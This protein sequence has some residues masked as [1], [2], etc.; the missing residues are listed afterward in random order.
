MAGRW[1]TV[2]VE[3]VEGACGCSGLPVRKEPAISVPPHESM[4]GLYPARAMSHSTSS[5]ADASPAELKQRMAPQSRPAMQPL[6][7]Q[8]CGRQA[9]STRV[10]L[11][12]PVNCCLL[13]PSVLLHLAPPAPPHSHLDKAWHHTQH[14]DAGCLHKLAKGA[15]PGAAVQQ[16]DCGA[17]EQRCGWEDAEGEG[18]A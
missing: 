6:A 18:R 9:R 1:P 2:G 17:V 13:V 11:G 16:R 3:N 10:T 14:R 12:A 8:A 7:R 15:P 5:G 4:T